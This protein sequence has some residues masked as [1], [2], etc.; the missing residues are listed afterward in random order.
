MHKSIRS[1]LVAVLMISILAVPRQIV[2]AQVSIPADINKTFDPISIA[3]SETSLLSVTI[4]NPNSFPLT[5]A[6]WTDNMPSQITVVGIVSNTCGGT[7][8]ANN[9]SS[10]ISLSN[11]T[12]P[13]RSGARPGEC[14]VTVEVTSSSP[15]NWDNVIPEGE[16][17]SIGQGGVIVT[18]TSEARIT[19]N[20]SGTGVPTVNKSFSPTNIFAGGI[21]QL[22]IIIENNASFPLTG[23]SITDSLPANV[24]VA[25]PVT[26]NLSGCGGSASVSATA[27]GGIVTL[28]NGT[29][30]AGAT[31]MITI[32]VTGDMQGRYTNTIP[33]RALTNNQ[34]LTNTTDTT[35]R[36][37]IREIGLT[38]R[39]SPST[40]EPGDTTTLIITLQNPKS[41]PYTS[42]NVTDPMPA[43]LVPVAGTETTTCGGTVVATSTSFTL[44]GG[45]IPAGTPANPG[46]C[47]ISVQVI[48]PLGTSSGT[49]T[50][51]VPSTGL[52]TDQGIG[53]RSDV[54]A[55]LN[56]AGTQ[57][58]GSKS[59]SP[60][61]I[62][63][64]G[65]SRL[66]IQFRAP[67]DT[68][69]TNFSVTDNLPT[70]ITIS[71]STAATK[72]ANCIGGTLN[73]PTG[74]MTISWTGGTINAGQQCTIDVWVTSSTPTPPNTPYIN[75]ISPDQ[76]TNDQGR[77]PTDTITDT[78][79]V[80]SGGNLAISLVK[81]FF[82]PGVFNGASS[83]MSIR[84]INPGNVT[85]TGIAFTDNMPGG[86]I[87]ANPVNFNVGT[88]G[89]T[90]TG[91][92][93]DGSFS[94]S[95]GRLDPRGSC[96]LTLSATMNVNGNLVNTIGARTVTTDQGATNPDATS[97][98]LTNQPGA[99]VSKVFS[100]N[101]I[102]AGSYSLLTIT[103]Q[104][105][106]TIELI[107]MRLSDSLPAGLVIAS[108]SAPAPVNNCGGT[109]T[110][111][112]GT[113][114]IQL[115]DGTLAGISSCTMVVAITGANPG[116]Y[117]NTIPVGALITDPSVNLSNTAPAIDTLVITGEPVPGGGGGG[118]GGG[119]ADDD[120][121]PQR[122]A[123]TNAF[124]IPVTGFK[125]NVATDLS[126]VPMESYT[127]TGDV[128]LVVP[129]LGVN[130]P[131][132]GVPKKDGTWNVTWLA[133][134]AG[135]LEGSA[136]PSWNGNSVLTGHVYL[137]NGLPGPFVN[138]NK[139]KFGDK[140][141]V[142]AF[143]QKYTFD[144]QTNEIVNPTDRSVMKHEEKPWLTLVTCRDYDEKTD[145]YRSRVV[146]RAVLVDVRP[147]K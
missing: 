10:T 63:A 38:K 78:L 31:C 35:D 124:L 129:S 58:S 76:I 40:I 104:N 59:F 85:L 11:G 6:S 70:G 138:L 90:L 12:V 49:I 97:A 5:N 98:T 136:F 43:P 34:N 21:S 25:D 126:N 117:Q 19:L 114:L 79:T 84:L 105:T 111:V 93:G 7:V 82:P 101:P 68:N 92:P 87:L 135:W 9:G 39:F 147:I 57:L 45:T 2:Y 69:L 99:T 33:A 30:A 23:A 125:A 146:V 8:T 41:T 77:V 142:Y 134:Q 22:S 109:L 139:L 67:G 144:V 3:P 81:G 113:Q 52:T 64:G 61:P 75:T 145:T 65:N 133:D 15:G 50:N 32:N 66:R 137:A 42:V 143:G 91:A 140:I 16:L 37:T 36:L 86:M 108:G 62:S 17:S 88:C 119:G 44:T 48:V 18:N 122:A 47:E 95:G 26:T 46:T 20:V 96:V 56:V 110:A 14:T 128:L 73:A 112:A 80:T 53:L 28:N 94:F 74:G 115:V 27:G 51:T 83:T 71:N 89:G 132:V 106:G 130:I 102:P 103:I 72:S 54:S 131:V 120:N 24:F 60:D 127:S 107:G 116:D 29:I 4:F 141:V 121:T 123:Q 55:N 13:A 118:G 1:L 100:P